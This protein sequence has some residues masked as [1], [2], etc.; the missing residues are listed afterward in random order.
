M[1]EGVDIGSGD[2]PLSQRI[3]LFSRISSVKEWDGEHGDAQYME[4]VPAD[5]F[6]FVHSSHCLEEMKDPVVALGHWIRIT[7]PGGHVIVTVPDEDMYEQGH[8][9]S[10]FNSDHRWTF[11]V[12]KRSSWSS[13]SIS[14][15]QLLSDSTHL[16][17]IERI[18]VVR[19]HY[20]MKLEG[21]VKDLTKDPLV[22]CAIEF[23]MRKHTQPEGQKII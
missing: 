11:T 6:D 15:L 18:E 8:W 2:D 10:I 7:K 22:E 23:V 9:P 21:D 14:I 20:P 1:G 17:S 4:G 3:H 12:K 5:H 16:V 13:R 19:D